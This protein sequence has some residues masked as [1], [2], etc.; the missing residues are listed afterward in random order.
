MCTCLSAHVPAHLRACV[1]VY[2]QT[3]IRHRSHGFTEEQDSFKS[4]SAI[5]CCRKKEYYYCVLLSIF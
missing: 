4:A 2:Q 1:R 3:Y 5:K